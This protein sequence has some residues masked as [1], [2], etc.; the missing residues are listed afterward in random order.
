MDAQ[1]IDK[2]V[3]DDASRYFATSKVTRIFLDGYALIIRMFNLNFF[4]LDVTSYCLWDSAQTLDMIAFRYVTTIYSLL[5]VTLVILIVHYCNGRRFKGV[6]SKVRSYRLTTR[7]TLI[8]GIT[9]FL[10]LSYSEFT[11]S[12]VK[13]LLSVSLY[14]MGHNVKYNA[15]YYNGELTHLRGEHLF[16]AIPAVFV[17]ATL[18]LV[19]PLLLISY[20]LCYKILSLLKLNETKFSEVLCA[21]IPLEKMKPL[22]D[23]F[24]TSYK[25]G[26]RFFCG[27]YF[28]FRLSTLSIQAIIPAS[29]N[30]VYFYAAISVQSATIFAIHA[31]CRPYKKKKHNIIEGIFLFDIA[32]I[33][34]TFSTVN[35]HFSNVG[36]TVIQLGLLYLPLLIIVAYSGKAVVRKVKNFKCFK[37]ETEGS[38]EYREFND[39][40]L[41]NEAENRSN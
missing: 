32:V 28:I 14:S 24:Q 8:H 15:V 29:G 34:I 35:I 2:I 38:S 39:S 25:D 3:L 17:F 5:L 21:C 31:I 20:P 1:T 13:L 33:A 7:S 27:L 36:I 22:F 6:V 40:I 23:S 19:P 37:R 41:F 18:G 9:G 16:Y 10:V 12:S 30:N 11:T 26:Y 4:Q